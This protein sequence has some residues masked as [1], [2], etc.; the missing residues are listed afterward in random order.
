[1][2]T[3]DYLSPE[4]LNSPQNESL[5]ALWA[6]KTICYPD[7]KN[8]IMSDR[9]SYS[10]VDALMALTGIEIEEEIGRKDTM[11]HK[12]KAPPALDKAAELVN[13]LTKASPKLNGHLSKNLALLQSQL[14]LSNSEKD[15]LS[16]C[17]LIR[18]NK[19]LTNMI[20]NIE[21]ETKEKIIDYFSYILDLPKNAIRSALSKQG[22][23]E[24]SGLLTLRLREFQLRFKHSLIL[25]DGLE[26]A[27]I[28][29]VSDPLELMAQ[30]FF[31]SQN[32]TL[33]FQDFP[34]LTKEILL[35]ENYLKSVNSQKHLKKGANILIYGE[36]G[37]GKTEL[38]RMLAKSLSV[39][40][41]EIASSDDDGEALDPQK[42]INQYKLAQFALSQTNSFILFDEVEG[43]FPDSGFLSLFNNGRHSSNKA[44]INKLLEENLIPAFWITNNISEIDPAY[45][46]RF[47]LVIEVHT[48]P[49]SVRAK[50]IDEAL[51]TLPVSTAFKEHLSHQRHLVPAVVKR[52]AKVV[53]ISYQTTDLPLSKAIETDL[54]YLINATL[55]AQGKEQIQFTP[56]NKLNY[57]LDFIHTDI[58]L[59][60]LVE[61]IK[62]RKQ[63][64]LCL[65]GLP[66]TG[67]TAFGHHLANALDQPLILKKASDLLSPYVGMAEK[68]IAQAFKEAKREGAILQIDEADTFLQSREN[69]VRSWEVSQVNEL[70]TQME[71]FE[72]IF[73]ASTNLMD[74]IDTAAMRRF[75]LKLEFKP[76]TPAQSFKML[77]QLLQAQG[78]SQ[79][80]EPKI[81]KNLEQL[82][83][84]TPGD[85][86]A[87]IR[88]FE[89]SDQKLTPDT[90]IQALEEECQ[91]KPNYHTSQGIGFLSAL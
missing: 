28:S 20:G 29:K 21:F 58:D 52:A 91:H 90:L 57:S 76:M 17:I 48:P 53:E 25:I 86:A 31:K 79:I 35:T 89:I 85:F 8:D 9:C 14:R 18:T 1:M 32:P 70:L 2:N 84:L 38:T 56:K 37:T 87:V 62:K 61:G 72:G 23:L 22:I 6:A 82:N 68:N 16:L 51:H 13:Q 4:I 44:W 3:I 45:I 83:H 47:D 74:H 69:A 59:F 41:Y 54:M 26:D 40:L 11:Q 34:H 64:R 63:G 15:I 78:I 36:P 71:S 50:I 65:Y 80:Y 73:I 67:K 60:N 46:R 5:L 66:G 30:Y 27:M 75:D 43:V 19:N 81:L 77:T 49:K 42:R 12:E 88:K 10:M 39:D 33:S 55:E 7:I 24:K